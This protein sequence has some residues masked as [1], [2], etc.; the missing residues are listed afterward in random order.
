MEENVVVNTE[1]KAIQ[2]PLEEVKEKWID[3][4]GHMNVAY[5]TFA[6]DRA[7]DYFLE[8]ILGIGPTYVKEKKQGPYSLQANYNYLQELRLRDIFHSK[9]FILDADKKRIHLVL[10]MV[11]ASNNIKVAVCETILIN[12]DLDLRRSTEY[13]DWVQRKIFEYKKACE[14]FTKPQEVGKSIT[15]KKSSKG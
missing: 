5:Y 12:V 2:S 14:N 4:N 13:P 7:I 3:Y 6:F 15:I 8:N 10:E 9:I 1:L 11:N